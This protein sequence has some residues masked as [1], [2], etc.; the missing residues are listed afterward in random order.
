MNLQQAGR[1][2]SLAGKLCAFFF[3]L[4]FLAAIDGLIS[5]FRQPENLV[6]LLASESTDINGGLKGEVTDP[7][8]LS[9]D[10]GS[11]S[12]E[13]SF[14]AVHA[15]FWLGGKMWRGRVRA[16]ST[17]RPGEYSLRVFSRGE[18]ENKP[19]AVFRVKVYA[20]HEELRKSSLSIARRYLDLSPWS[21]FAIFL[22]ASLLLLGAVYIFSQKID[23]LLAMEG[24]AEIYHIICGENEQEVSFGLGSEHGL[25]VGERLEVF[26]ESGRAV[27]SVGVKKV[28]EADSTAVAEPGC[29]I[30]PGY[31][32]VM[33]KR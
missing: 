19:A 20:D 11:D 13:V 5:H 14:E 4:L 15:G 30:K 6:E 31:L 24:K 22:P 8:E 18:P 23:G 7:R 17:V 28:M 9:Y 3:A 29:P 2:Q 21:I 10:S 32:V 26:D 25:K 12:I 27:G 16:G 1:R 33:G